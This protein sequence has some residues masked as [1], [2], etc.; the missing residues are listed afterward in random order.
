MSA[1]KCGHNGASAKR[2]DPETEK[3]EFPKTVDCDDT[4][5]G[6]PAIKWQARRSYIAMG[7]F[8][9]SAG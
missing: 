3:D 1:G 7:R 4:I 6:V 8:A 5:R 2:N 9:S